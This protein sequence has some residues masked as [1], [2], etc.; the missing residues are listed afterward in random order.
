MIIALHHKQDMREMGGLFRI[1][2]I[3]A[4]TAWIGSLALIGFPFTAGFF[5]KD[6]IIESVKLADR[7]GAGFA[8]FAV[9]A[10]VLV[11]A[12]YTFRMLYLT[13]HGKSRTD[14]KRFCTPRNRRGW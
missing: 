13:F 10:G 6:I 1:M 14:R 11:T 9:Y 7:T 8:T 4:V 3:T 2:P 5:S 12:L